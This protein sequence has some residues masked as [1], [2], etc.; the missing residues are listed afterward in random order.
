MVGMVG[1]VVEA[2]EEGGWEGAGREGGDDEWL[3]EDQEEGEE[4]LEHG[5]LTE[6]EGRGGEVDLVEESGL[7]LEDVL[8]VRSI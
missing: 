7:L 6:W 1:G 3:A 4:V 2:E 8:G 5:G